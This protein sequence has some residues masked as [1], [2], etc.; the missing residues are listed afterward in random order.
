[1]ILEYNT[2][3]TPFQGTSLQLPLNGNVDCTVDWGDG[4]MESFTTSGNKYHQYEEDGIYTVSIS[5]TLTQF[6]R[7]DHQSN[8]ILA[9]ITSL[10]KVIS[11]GSIGLTSL[12]GA[13][14]DASNLQE[15]PMVIPETISDLSFAFRGESGQGSITNLDA[16]NVNNV[17]NMSTMFGANFLFNQ[18][19]SAWNVS[20]VTDMSAMFGSA[21]DFNQ[22]ISSWNVGNVTDMSGMFRATQS[23]NQDISSWD[24]DK[25]TNMSGMFSNSN[26]NPNI[27]GWDVSN[28]TDMS[29]MFWSNTS[30][31]QD[32]SG[33]DVGNVVNMSGMFFSAN[34]F[35]QD[36]SSWDVSKVTDMSKMFLGNDSFNQDIG[37]WNVGSVVDMSYIFTQSAF[38]QDLSNWNTSNV[39]NLAGFFEGL[40]SDVDL[41]IEDWNTSKV[42]DMS[43]L[44]KG[45]HTGYNPDISNWDLS[46][47]ITMEGMFFDNDNFNQDLSLWDVSNVQNMSMMFYMADFV[48]DN[49]DLTGWNVSNVQDMSQMF[50]GNETFNQDISL[51]NVQDLKNMDYMFLNN[52]LFK[53]DLSGWNVS[54]LESARYAFVGGATLSNYDETLINWAE[55]ILKDSVRFDAGIVQYSS[56]EASAARQNIKTN[57]SWIINDGGAHGSLLWLGASRSSFWNDASNWNEN[58]VPTSEDNVVLPVLENAEAIIIQSGNTAD[59]KDLQINSNASLSIQSGASFINSG[60]I[61]NNGTINV[62]RT[63]SDGEWHLISSPNDQ[64]TAE[65]F[66]GDYL[67][68]W[69]E[70]TATWTDISNITTSLNVGKGYSLWGVAK[71]TNYAF[72][73]TPNTGEVITS[74]TYTDNCTEGDCNDGA[75]LLG[76]PYP[77][78]IDWNGLDETWGAVYIWNPNYDNGNGTF[79]KYISWV[80]GSGT[81]G[82]SQYIAPMQG[83]FMV[84]ESEDNGSDFTINNTNRTHTGANIFYKEESSIEN[85]LILAAYTN[86]VADELC[87]KSNMVASSEFDKTYDAYKFFSN[88]NGVA[89]LYSISGE[90]SLSIDSRSEIELVQLGFRNNQNGSYSIG[91]NEIDGISI[92]ELEDT[93]LNVFYDLSNGIYEFDWLTS[94]SEERFILHLRA[95]GT[96]ALEENDAQVYAADGQVY[97][98]LNNV[99][100]FKQIM[101]FDLAG[102]LIFD[103]LLTNQSLQN[104]ELGNENG[105]YLVQLLGENDYFTQKII[106]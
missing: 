55:L 35:N 25:V 94:D 26:F 43:F 32:I 105:A 99:E 79:G 3:L 87:V 63:I 104:F 59:C 96:S 85:G 39:E 2:N 101:I 30:F 12:S 66:L 51:W 81:N 80:N 98:S 47:V 18:D 28:V 6:G 23:F 76:N 48:T 102:R 24:I 7:G 31:N 4:N 16:W 64:T 67:Q 54:N 93:K 61:V 60:I 88:L 62:N 44:L 38:N 27:S 49:V 45:N 33:W 84:A 69:N 15:V 10:S 40:G 37:N 5:G 92:V 77:S 82:G 86:G 22:N 57:Y 41:K 73:G 89:E 68:N 11:F 21:R 8:S 58:T 50:S 78:S 71:A 46:N 72:T 70:T 13:F 56:E 100:E 29:N 103:E 91:I 90:K 95:T 42:T 97:V 74:I 65:T 106:L 17:S 14:E 83:F 1:M 36:I 75:N 9:G 52:E 34:N 53:Q 19:I 20:N